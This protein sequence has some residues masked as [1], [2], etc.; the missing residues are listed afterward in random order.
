[1]ETYDSAFTEI[2]VMIRN[3][4]LLRRDKSGDFQDLLGGV[5]LLQGNVTAPPA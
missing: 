5:W 3:Q 1:M 2:L 4:I